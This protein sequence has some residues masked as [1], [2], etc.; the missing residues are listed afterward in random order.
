M[1]KYFINI[2]ISIDQFA[3]TLLGGDPD[4][5]IS[6]RLGKL[7][8]RHGGVIPWYRFMSGLI[9]WLLDKIDPHHSTDA[10]EDDEGKNSILDKNGVKK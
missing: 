2:L 10:I 8:R 4:E 5:T 6:S 9:D 7:K 3:N 1:K